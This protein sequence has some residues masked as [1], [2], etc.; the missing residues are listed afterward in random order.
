[1]LHSSIDLHQ[2]IMAE[3]GL[4]KSSSGTTKES[5]YTEIERHIAQ[6]A[7]LVRK[8]RSLGG[9]A[10]LPKMRQPGAVP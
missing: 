7:D 4:L 6:S 8:A 2:V 9:R 10:V 5:S 3:V 1:M